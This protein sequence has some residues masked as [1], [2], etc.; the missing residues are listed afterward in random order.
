[1]RQQAAIDDHWIALR[2][3]GGVVVTAAVRVVDGVAGA[4]A[5]GDGAAGVAV[6][7]AGV[8]V[9][10]GSPSCLAKNVSST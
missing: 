5:A 10:S 8:N 7:G 6:P 4:G 1:V 3:A 9:G 2:A